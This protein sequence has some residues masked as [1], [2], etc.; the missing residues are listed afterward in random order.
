[1]ILDELMM[2]VDS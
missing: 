2:L 1:M